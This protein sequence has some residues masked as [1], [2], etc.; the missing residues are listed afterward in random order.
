MK[1]FNIN[2]KSPQVFISNKRVKKKKKIKLQAEYYTGDEFFN[3]LFKSRKRLYQELQ[4]MD[5]F[6]GSA[7][8]R[9]NIFARVCAKIKM[10]FKKIK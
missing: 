5:E 3:D 10:C 6:S 2:D 7:I 9:P 1:T 4:Q 8:R